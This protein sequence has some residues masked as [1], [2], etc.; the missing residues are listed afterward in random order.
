MN[1]VQKK[2][3]LNVARALREAR[4]EAKRAFHMGTF[5]YDRR[6]G[7][8]AC[9]TPGCALGHFAAREDL[10]RLMRI[11]RIGEVLYKKD[12]EP[13]LLM[14][15]CSYEDLQEYFGISYDEFQEIFRSDGCGEAQ[16]TIQAARYI[17]KFVARKEKTS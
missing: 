1:K 16:T 12:G 7:Q 5:V 15:D 3:L 10:Q 11:N 13:L 17:E 14:D 6:I 4:G 8:Y 2:R 9:G